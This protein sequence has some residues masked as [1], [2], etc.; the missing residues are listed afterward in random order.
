MKKNLDITLLSTADWDN[1]F[2]T[3][4][5]HV[6]VEF[7]KQG[8]RVFY[9]DSLGLRR[10]S[11]SKRDISRIC[12]R[13]LKAIRP[14]QEKYNNVWVW[15][16]IILPWHNNKIVRKINSFMLNS[17]ICFWRWKLNFNN[18]MLWTYNP[19]TPTLINLNNF[20]I[21]I[22]H[23]VDEIKAQPGMPAKVLEI[24]EKSLVEQVDFV[25]VTSRKLEETRCKWNN[26]V[27]YFSNVA[28]YE[29]FSQALSDELECPNDLKNFDGPVLGFIG[30]ISG[31]KIN[32]ELIKYIADTHPEWTI[33]L[34]GEVGEGDPWTDVSILSKYENIVF[35]GPKPYSLLPSYLK[36]FD[37]ALLPNNINE[38]TDSMFPMK[39]FEYLS[40][41]KPVVSVDLK[42]LREFHNIAEIATTNE[43]FVELIKKVLTGNTAPIDKRLELAKEYTYKSRNKKIFDIINGDKS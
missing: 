10:P 12:R 23:C 37:V 6:A 36:R 28:D 25:F 18:D 11:L 34:I 39:F 3:N 26:N 20:D 17:M 41:G 31:Y 35:L 22:Y 8:H 33:A 2:W 19:I 1:P 32:F 13:I 15:S 9:I 43:E 27:H 16:P 29:H 21:K 30:A 14:P 40:A 24:S 5:Q 4:K 38:Y 7:S 42:A